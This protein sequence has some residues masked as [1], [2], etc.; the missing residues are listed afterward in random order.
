MLLVEFASRQLTLSYFF[1]SFYVLS[2]SL[3]LFE[4]CIRIG[5]IALGA[6]LLCVTGRLESEGD[7]ECVIYQPLHS[8]E[9]PNEEQPW[10]KPRPH[11]TPPEL[12]QHFLQLTHGNR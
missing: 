8:C 4:T 10:D 7:F 3:S 5:V 6:A 11:P 2:L 1:L 12:R 9:R